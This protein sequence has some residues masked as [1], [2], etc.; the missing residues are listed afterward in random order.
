M[1]PHAYADAHRQSRDEV[2]R[3]VA[4]LAAAA[5]N[6]KPS[7]REWSVGEC[8]AHLSAVGAACLPALEAATEPGARRR[9]RSGDDEP[10]YGRMA[11]HLRRALQPGTSPLTTDRSLDPS[12][13]GT[14]SDL[15]PSATLA[16]FDQTV[17][18]FVAVCAAAEGLD[19]VRI[20][21]ANPFTAPLRLPLGA[22]L[23]VTGL[24]ARRHAA[25]A[26]RVARSAVQAAR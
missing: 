19:L 15:D 8:V 24:H 1:T 12:R 7:P 25:Q 22:V 14:A 23:E 10:S 16:V 17:E 18:R 13:G 2:H 9:E 20:K 4:D 26:A 11:A 21:V 3:I 5:F 6:W